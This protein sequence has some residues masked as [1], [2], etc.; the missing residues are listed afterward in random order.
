[1]I[2]DVLILGHKG[3][4]GNCV[5]KYF[6]LFPQFRVFTIEGRF[7]EKCFLDSYFS[8][9]SSV[10]GDSL[11]V[12][13]CVGAI[14]QR[15]GD[16]SINHELPKFL[17][18]NSF[19]SKMVHASSDCEFS[20]KKTL[21]K[22]YSHEDVPDAEDEYGKSKINGSKIILN[23][24]NGRVLRTSI[25]GISGSK[26]GLLSWY[27]N[28]EGKVEGYLNHLWSGVTTLEWAKA[29]A[30]I[31]L[32]FSDCSNLVQI[33]CRPLSKA[34]LLHYFKHVFKISRDIECVV[35]ENSKNMI[36]ESNYD[37]ENQQKSIYVQLKE[38]KDF[39]G[40]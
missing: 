6:S 5:F 12:V 36:L 19:G 1:M 25:V 21:G 32:N 33:S 24:E 11:F 18:E 29:A 35:T 15:T 13:N 27:M 16:F 17:V 3:M 8:L 7:P 9:V 20:G 28:G 40:I 31:I 14:P 10:G 23:Y 4:L 34:L 26:T 38:L 37:Y 39:Y 2:R 22:S 30:Q